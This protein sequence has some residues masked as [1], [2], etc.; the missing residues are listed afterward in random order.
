MLIWQGWKRLLNDSVPPCTHGTRDWCI[1]VDLNNNF[2][3]VTVTHYLC[4]I[5]ASK[6][7]YGM[8][9]M[10]HRLLLIRQRPL[11]LDESRI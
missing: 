10:L 6:Y 1:Y 11:L 3:H 8:V 4:V 5:D 9:V 2:Y 7:W